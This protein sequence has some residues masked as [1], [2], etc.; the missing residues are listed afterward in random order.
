MV[1]DKD[2]GQLMRAAREEQGYTLEQAE[3]ETK[4]RK[5]YL[6]ALE[7]DNFSV[8]P[9]QVY[10]VGFVRK[11]C[12]FLG[13][14]AQEKI[15]RYKQ[16]SGGVKEETPAPP[17]ANYAD[18][19]PM[20]HRVS[21]RNIAAAIVFLVMAIWLGSYLTNYFAGKGSEQTK[22]PVTKPPVSSEQPNK[23]GG[24]KPAVKPNE[25]LITLTWTDKSWYSVSVDGGETEQGILES[26][27][28]K[29][30]RGKEKI[31]LRLGNAGG[32]K[33]S[34]DGGEPTYLGGSGEVINKEYTKG[35]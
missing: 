14:D 22:P 2:F 12:M 28:V 4:I 10:A 5:F 1:M 15:H 13:I 18:K 7:E 16:L 21:T 27:Q 30:Y 34:V 24:N 31:Y 33:V 19:P 32:V 6:R 8:M 11:Y 20:I 9:A 25:V 35:Q 17:A 26:G 23:P 3:E 29:E